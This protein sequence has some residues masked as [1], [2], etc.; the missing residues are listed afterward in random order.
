MKI[1]NTP[2]EVKYRI[3]TNAGVVPVI[4]ME[5]NKKE[6]RAYTYKDFFVRNPK[7]LM[8][9]TGVKDKHGNEIYEG[10]ILK[11]EAEAEYPDDNTVSDVIFNEKDLCFQIRSNPK[12]EK[13]GT[14]SHGLP[15]TWGA[16]ASL[17]I[18]GNIHE[19]QGLLK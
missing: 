18:V 7:T 9:Y 5:W 12:D 1:N 2:R 19:N 3:F 4:K 11:A 17:E 14:Y 13:Y 8:Q 10:Y 16:W 15:L 6:V